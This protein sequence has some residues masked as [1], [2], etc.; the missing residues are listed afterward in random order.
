[1]L[2]DGEGFEP[3][4]PFSTHAFQACTID[5][6]VTHPERSTNIVAAVYDR[7]INFPGLTERRA[8]TDSELKPAEQFVERQLDADEKFAEVRVLRAHRIKT[9]FVN[10]CLNL[11]RVARK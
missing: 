1:M 2:A 7:R 9:H 11:K 8:A 5:H 3:S 10:D 6:S 4:V